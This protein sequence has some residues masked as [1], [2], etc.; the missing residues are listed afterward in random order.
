MDAFDIDLCLQSSD[1]SGRYAFSRQPAVAHWNL[2]CLGQACCPDRAR[3][4]TIA[5]ADLSGNN[6][7]VRSWSQTAG[8]AS[9]DAPNDGDAVLVQDTLELL[10]RHRV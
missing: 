6:S 9:A 8:Q 10:D 4:Q 2:R 3:E 1:D 5:A 7:S